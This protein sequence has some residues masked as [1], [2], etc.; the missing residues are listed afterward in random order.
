MFQGGVR[1]WGTQLLEE[2]RGCSS[3]GLQ[4]WEENEVQLHALA[5]L[6]RKVGGSNTYEG[7][8]EGQDAGWPGRDLGKG[9]PGMM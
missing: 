1:G 3:R 2:S 5:D 7:L 9:C 4:A 8:G 6:V